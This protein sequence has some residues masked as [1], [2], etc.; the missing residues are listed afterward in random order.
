MDIFLQQEELMR[1]HLEEFEQDIKQA[2]TL[3]EKQIFMW[4]IENYVP[5][6][7]LKDNEFKLLFYERFVVQPEE[8]FRKLFSYLEIPFQTKLLE[9]VHIPSAEV[10]KESAIIRGENLLDNW[11]KNI[12][13]E[14]IS[15]AID[16]L[17]I[18]YLDKLYGS[19]SLPLF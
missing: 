3:F 18:F 7:Q 1:D 10:R 14:Q 4:A 5:L 9:K 11:K 17:S 2:D 8:E 15:K 16:I 19:D 12:T 13:T 6:K